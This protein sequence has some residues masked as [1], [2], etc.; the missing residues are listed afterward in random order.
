MFCPIRK[1]SVTPDTDTT[2]F[3]HRGTLPLLI[4]IPHL[5]TWLPAELRATLSDAANAMQDTDWHLDQLYS[6]AAPLGA[7]V[8]QARVSRYAI[9]L[10]RPPD[11]ASLYP[12]QTTTGLCPTETFEGARL[13]KTGQD[14]NSAECAR[15][16]QAYWQPY[17]D[18]L[19][20][21]L[22]RLRKLHGRVLL[23]DAH[24]IASRSPR[25]F[26][27]RLPDLNFG[28]V[29]GLSCDNALVHA[30][31]AVAERSPFSHVLN[32]RFKGG[33]ITRH[34]GRPGQGIQAIQLE[35]CQ[36]LYMQEN[37]PFDYLPTLAQQVQPTLQALIGAALAQ[38]P[39]APV[40]T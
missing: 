17:H 37:A 12:G 24:S 3:L 15:R 38:L 4:S 6:F 22:A 36:C 32:G 1:K 26:D 33:Y 34:Y 28:T 5:G 10:N 2:H 31:L 14:P 18:A 11:N 20:S 7:S 21:E 27:G 29:D 13:Y 19:G 8:L 40:G 16:L 35:M 23:W 39:H 30:M 25:L 9:D